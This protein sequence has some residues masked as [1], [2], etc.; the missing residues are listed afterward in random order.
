M[1]RV[2]LATVWIACS[3]LLLACGGLENGQQGEFGESVKAIGLTPD[4]VPPKRPETLTVIQKQG[5]LFPKTRLSVQEAAPERRRPSHTTW[6]KRI[7]QD[8]IAGGVLT[9]SIHVNGTTYATGYFSGTIRI[10]G[11]TWSSNGGEDGFVAHFDKNGKLQWL[12]TFGGKGN[13]R[14]L[15]VAMGCQNRLFVVGSYSGEFSLL[16]RVYSTKNQQAAVLLEVSPLSGA[17]QACRIDNTSKLFSYHMIQSDNKTCHLAVAG[18]H[19]IHSPQYGVRES[20]LSLDPRQLQGKPA[21]DISL[22]NLDLLQMK[23]DSTGALVLLGRVAFGSSLRIGAL[24]QATKS[25][26]AFLAKVSS[27]G[28]VQWLNKVEYYR[29]R[30]TETMRLAIDLSTDTLFVVGEV[31][32]SQFSYDGKPYEGNTLLA[33]F[34]TKGTLRWMNASRESWVPEGLV[35][36]KGHLF[37]LGSFLYGGSLE[38]KGVALHGN[39]GELFLAGFDDKGVIQSGRLLTSQGRPVSGLQLSAKGF[40]LHPDG[41]FVIGQLEYEF[42]R[43]PDTYTKRDLMGFFRLRHIDG[44]GTVQWSV[45]SGTGNGFVTNIDAKIDG[46]GNLYRLVRAKGSLQVEG[47]P[48]IVG[49]DWKFVLLKSDKQGQLLWSHTLNSKGKPLLSVGA[50]GNV[51]LAGDVFSL[52]SKSLPQAKGGRELMLLRLST[53][54]QLLGSVVVPSRWSGSAS[55]ALALL[56]QA[57][58]GMVYVGYYGI[59]NSYSLRLLRADLSFFRE[60]SFPGIRSYLGV[61]IVPDKKSHLH[62]IV[63]IDS[64]NKPGHVKTLSFGTKTVALPTEKHISVIAKL[65]PS[66]IF[67]WARV[68]VKKHYLGAVSVGVSGH[69]VLRGHTLE[70]AAFGTQ[71]AVSFTEEDDAVIVLGT[72]GMVRWSKVIRHT[73]LAGIFVDS[74][75]RVLLAGY[76]K[77][78]TTLGQLTFTK[79]KETFSDGFVVQLGASGQVEWGHSFASYQID[80]LNVGQY[81]LSIRPDGAGHFLLLGQFWHG[82]LRLKG[83]THGGEK[84]YLTLAARISAKG[85][86]LGGSVATSGFERSFV[87]GGTL[88]LLGTTTQSYMSVGP[89]PSYFSGANEDYWVRV[90]LASWK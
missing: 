34:G 46:K 24:Q 4:P 77:N 36:E 8:V 39:D 42:F 75:G 20:V 5:R 63:G 60:F 41:G 72:D 2:C 82:P 52:D 78:T 53:D 12:R 67:A 51:L 59:P 48:I 57:P 58:N 90:D 87:H 40:A 7:G 70:Q 14:L 80:L 15:G 65:L 21:W 37:M 54:G 44:T 9:S 28:K 16:G 49:E 29:G 66:G 22:E 35:Y 68:A 30:S 83:F 62:V 25:T 31:P 85:D 27:T 43:S 55:G 26:G 69:V 86:L 11:N 64:Y 61:H 1:K 38:G 10:Q 88:Y 3:W 84:R 33:S 74:V 17:W 79:R 18:L 32:Y 76:V 71:K 45:R 50:D 19:Y 6:G 81:A 56:G 47:Q 23:H 89:Y 73:T 13:E